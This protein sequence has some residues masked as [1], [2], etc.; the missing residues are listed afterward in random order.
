[1]KHKSE[2][3]DMQFL[4]IINHLT[5][6][7]AT[8]ILSNFFVTDFR[9]CQAEKIL[10]NDRF[11]SAASDLTQKLPEELGRSTGKYIRRSLSGSNQ[12]S[13][14]PQSP[15]V[16]LFQP[17][18][19]KQ[20]AKSDFYN[21]EATDNQKSICT[22]RQKRQIDKFK[23]LYEF[24]YKSFSETLLRNRIKKG[25]SY[26]PEELKMVSKVNLLTKTADLRYKRQKL[27]KM[28]KELGV[29]EDY[30]NKD[31]DEGVLNKLEYRISNEQKKC[32]AI[33]SPRR[34]WSPDSEHST[35]QE[36][37]TGRFPNSPNGVRTIRSRS[38]RSISSQES[39]PAIRPRS[40]RERRKKKNRRTRKNL[41]NRD[42]RKKISKKSKTSRLCKEMM[43][44]WRK[45]AKCLKTVRLQPKQVVIT[46]RRKYTGL[47]EYLIQLEE[48]KN[49][50]IEPTQLISSDD[51]RKVRDPSNTLQINNNF[52]SPIGKILKIDHDDLREI[53]IG[54]DGTTMVSN[55]SNPTLDDY[56]F[57]VFSSSMV[58]FDADRILKFLNR[59]SHYF[60]YKLDEF[61]TATKK[62][63][64]IIPGKGMVFKAT[65]FRSGRTQKVIFFGNS[66]EL[67]SNLGYGAY[68]GTQ[69]K[70][71]WRKY[72]KIR[73]EPLIG[74]KRYCNYWGT[75]SRSKDGVCVCMSG[76]RGP[77]CDRL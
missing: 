23:H 18:T 13:T 74:G 2:E 19:N 64:R 7:T 48:E 43:Q 8:S 71:D 65:N 11:V 15:S 46:M 32:S 54:T 16:F 21:D 70:G 50:S 25:K 3:L 67:S 4:Q 66:R 34:S 37:K 6:L 14:S 47:M 9:C 36:S 38:P 63:Y 24:R 61:S 35:S 22:P 45:K 42:K 52:G 62:K 58:R 27:I 5:I 72:D 28:A 20:K 10:E 51:K 76:V 59:P 39:E 40:K 56:D 69:N 12:K 60:I 17:A 29:L 49:E 44:A 41:K 73:L 53:G 55:I 31:L 68:W 77:Y 26:S 1:M 57:R 33:K 30:I 75:H